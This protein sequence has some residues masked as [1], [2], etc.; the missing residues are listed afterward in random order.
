MKISNAR[1]SHFIATCGLYHCV[2][3]RTRLVT[4]VGGFFTT[5]HIIIDVARHR[6]YLEGRQQVLKAEQNVRGS[7]MRHQSAATHGC[8]H[9]MAGYTRDEQRNTAQG[10]FWQQ[11]GGRKLTR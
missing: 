1:S 11:G 9:L 6:L 3:L 4:S 8:D 7:C 2:F 5:I 10:P